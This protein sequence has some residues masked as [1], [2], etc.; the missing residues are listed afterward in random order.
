MRFSLLHT[1]ALSSV[2]FTII[3]CS[4]KAA[5]EAAQTNSLPTRLPVDV[6]VVSLTS[7]NRSELI[8]GSIMPSREV[9]V[10]SEI[11]K[12]ITSIGFRDGAVVS[13]GQLLY[14]LDDTDIRA[15]IRQLNAELQLAKV[16]ENRFYELLKT[17]TVRQEEYDMA[18]AKRQTLEATADYLR[19]ELSRTVITAPFSGRIGISKVQVGALVHPGLPLVTLQEQGQVKVE[20]NIPEKYLALVKPG[21]KIVFGTESSEQ[22]QATVFATEP[23]VDR[24]SRNIT[25]QAI[26]ENSAGRLRPGMSAR[27]RFKTED[28]NVKSITLPTHAFIP[29]ANGYSVFVVKNGLAKITPVSIGHRNEDE[30]VVTSGLQNGDSVLISNTLRA[31]DGTPVQIISNK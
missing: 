8:A 2:F 5:D 1:L 27:I 25:V 6:R 12:K 15:R 10:M 3:S 29:G 30:A 23:G 31:M 11:T 9:E 14:K 24:Q 13:K 21:S 4:S 20:F 16:N 22:L 28:E 26:A 17:E 19:A 18:L 7:L